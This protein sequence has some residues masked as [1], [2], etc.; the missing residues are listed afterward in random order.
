M[1]S[2]HFA[3]GAAVVAAVVIGVVGML[4]LPLALQAQNN[5]EAIQQL[6]TKGFAIAPVPLNLAGKDPNLVGL[7]SYLVNAVGDCNGCHSSGTP[8]SL[9]IYPYLPDGNPYFGQLEKLDPSVYLNGGTNFGAVGTPTGPKGYAGPAIITRNLTPDYTGRAE[10]GHT[11][12]EFSDIIK[13]GHDYDHVHPNC[14]PAQIQAINEGETPICIPTG[15]I[16]GTTFNN[17]PDGSLLQIMPWVTFSHM[18]DYDIKAIYEY[19]SAIPCI[20]NTLVPGPAGDPNELR[21][22]CGPGPIAPAVRADNDNKGPK[23]LRSP[24]IRV[25]IGGAVK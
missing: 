18:T 5:D 25:G 22:Q 11:L 16:P 17:I 8:D 1:G 3:K 14:T 7:G 24:R 10:G 2:V 13:N 9:F 20:D 19:L 21:N 6:V 4:S 23:A 12:A 15:V